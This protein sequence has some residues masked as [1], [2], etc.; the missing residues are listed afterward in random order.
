MFIFST[1][2]PVL[3]SCHC[4]IEICITWQS[5]INSLLLLYSADTIKSLKLA[6]DCIAKVNIIAV[7]DV[8]RYM[9]A[10]TIGQCPGEVLGP[11]Y[12][13]LILPTYIF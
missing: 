13:S 11:A 4:L 12:S 7:G 3:L 10:W 5:S 8:A 6:V 9:V 2:I 1:H